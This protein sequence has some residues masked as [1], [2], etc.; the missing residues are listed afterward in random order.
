MMLPTEHTMTEKKEKMSLYFS[1]CWMWIAFVNSV[2]YRWK[3]DTE[4]TVKNNGTN[5][6]YFYK[7]YKKDLKTFL[8]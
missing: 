1:S 4:N 6:K 5:S 7:K 2:S 3:E 8:I